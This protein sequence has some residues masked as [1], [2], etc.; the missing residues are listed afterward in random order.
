MSQSICNSNGEWNK[1]P[2]C[3][4]GEKKGLKNL[5]LKILKNLSN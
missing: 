5:N 1:T 4:R 2:K 3:I